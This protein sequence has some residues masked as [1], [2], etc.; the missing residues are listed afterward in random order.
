MQCLGL[1]SDIKQVKLYSMLMVILARCR[2]RVNTH[3]CVPG[4]LLI[5]P[6]KQTAQIPPGQITSQN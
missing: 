6:V 1:A 5:Y 4:S 3:A 2:S